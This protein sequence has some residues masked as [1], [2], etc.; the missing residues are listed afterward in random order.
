MVRWLRM[1]LSK[2]FVAAS[3]WLL[4]FAIKVHAFGLRV[5]AHWPKALAQNCLTLA[6]RIAP[7]DIRPRLIARLKGDDNAA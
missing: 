2:L 5:E 3:Y 1:R 6:V 4:A 7:P